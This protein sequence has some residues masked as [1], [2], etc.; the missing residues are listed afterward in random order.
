M[1]I[2]KGDLL[3]ERKAIKSFLES[4]YEL[5]MLKY[6]DEIERLEN[7]GEIKKAETLSTQLEE[8]ELLVAIHEEDIEFFKHKNYRMI[9]R[10]QQI[11]LMR[12]YYNCLTYE[13]ITSIFNLTRE[14]IRVSENLYLEYLIEEKARRLMAGGVEGP[15]V[16]TQYLEAVLNEESET[17]LDGLN[18]SIMNSAKINLREYDDIIKGLQRLFQQDPFILNCTYGANLEESLKANEESLIPAIERFLCDGLLDNDIDM[19]QRVIF[20]DIER[21]IELMEL[22]KNAHLNNDENERACVFQQQIDFYQKVF[23]IHHH[24]SEVLLKPNKVIIT[25]RA[26]SKLIGYPH[27]IELPKIMTQWEKDKESVKKAIKSYIQ[28]IVRAAREEF[29]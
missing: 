1:K 15:L 5:K 16:S 20:C 14:A 7:I 22:T 8:M 25:G 27:Y 29:G 18:G 13:K 10:G 3:A 11:M 6:E 2:F 26:I 9:Y 4:N 23:E 24:Y 19:C 12:S 28:V 21:F 17:S